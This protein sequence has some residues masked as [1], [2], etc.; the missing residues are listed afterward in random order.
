MIEQ[1]TEILTTESYQEY[2]ELGGCFTPE[3]YQLVKDIISLEK[4]ALPESPHT[5]EMEWISSNCSIQVTPQEK[6]IYY[7]LRTKMPYEGNSLAS[8]TVAVYTMSD[9]FL[10]REIFL[11]TDGTGEKFK[12]FTKRF[13]NIF[14]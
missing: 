13:P 12:L 3:D 10:M 7:F 1:E 14:S 8:D 6:L 2:R 5:K 11:V 4:V 9:Q